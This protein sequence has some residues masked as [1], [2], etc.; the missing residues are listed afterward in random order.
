LRYVR[1]YLHFLRFSISRAFEFRVDFYFRVVMDCVYY[2]VSIGF[3]AVLY[4]KTG[5]VGGWTVDQAYIFACGY[6]L[7]DAIQMTVFANNMWMLPIFVNKGDLDYYLVRPVSSLFFLSL[8]EF[9]ANS[10][11]NLVIA[12]GLLAWAL[13]RYPEPLGATRVVVFV[14]ML[15]NGA[16]VT[17]VL[18]LLFIT[19]VFWLHSGRGL[20]ELNFTIEKLAERPHQIYT[21]WLRGL[22]LTFVPFAL[23]SSV[24]SHALFS[25]LTLEG[26]LHMTAVTAGLFAVAVWFWRRGLRVY[27]S[28]S[29]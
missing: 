10:F 25:G 21:G 3:F 14:L 17:Y 15:L 19:P 1:L 26:L 28:A 6:M 12:S 7:V 13:A 23:L 11:V 22:L 4:T 27:S 18:R 2:A 16:F 29:S 9:A 8:R 5:V 20:D 24:P